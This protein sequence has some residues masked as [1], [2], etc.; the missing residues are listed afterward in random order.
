MRTNSI[1]DSNGCSVC[2]AGQENYTTFVSGT[3][4]GKKYCQ[5][6]YRM[7]EG[8]LFSTVAKTL[9]E[10][11]KRRDEWLAKKQE[12]TNTGGE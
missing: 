2:Q 11:R 9:K 1:N 8:T 5:Y 7:P 6:D 12:R 10:C 3:F 4:R